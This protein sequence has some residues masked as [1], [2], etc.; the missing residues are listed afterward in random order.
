M[1]RGPRHKSPEAAM[2]HLTNRVAGWT[3][4]FPF[5]N[6]QAR[7]QLLNMML[8]YVNVYRCRLAAFQIMGNHFHFIVHF[9]KPRQLS[10]QDLKSS[11]RKLYGHKAELKT[12]GWTDSQ[13]KAF[14]QRLFDVSK[15]MA[16]LDGEYAKWF[17]RRFGRRGHFWSDRFKKPRITRKRGRTRRYPVCGT[18]CGESWTCQETRAVEMGPQLGGD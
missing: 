7:L 1:A 3:N 16:N 11:A 14:N 9:E 15:L 4:W 17:N 13:W 6:R 5:E 12:A 8:F 18:Q 2:Y 10:H